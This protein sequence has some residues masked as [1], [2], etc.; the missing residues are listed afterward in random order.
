MTQ[1]RGKGSRHSERE[2]RKLI[3]GL[4]RRPPAG[5]RSR[6]YGQR[7]RSFAALKLKAFQLLGVQTSKEKT[8]L[9]PFRNFTNSKTIYSFLVSTLE[10]CDNSPTF[11]LF[12]RGGQNLFIFLPHFSPTRLI[13]HRILGE[14]GE[15]KFYNPNHIRNVHFHFQTGRI[16]CSGAHE[17]SKKKTRK[18]S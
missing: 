1:L 13:L 3:R 15:Y 2:E 18:P 4:G 7:V 5:P 14:R 8:H 9:P 17:G 16:V 11:T 12:S 6:A 10:V